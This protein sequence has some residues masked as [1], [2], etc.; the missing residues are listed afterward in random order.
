MLKNGLK[1][2]ATMLRYS[3][4]QTVLVLL[5]MVVASVFTT[6]TV[7]IN[8]N[9]VDSV[10]VFVRER[11]NLFELCLWGVLLFLSIMFVSFRTYFGKQIDI[12]LNRNLI[13]HFVP[14]IMGKLNKVEYSAFEDSETHNLIDRMSNNPQSVIIKCFNNLISLATCIFSIAGIVVYFMNISVV[15]TV[16]Y[17]VITLVYCY[18]NLMIE[19][20]YINLDDKKAECK[21]KAV[22]YNN[23]L[24]QKDSL[25]ELHILN[26]ENYIFSG[27]KNHLKKMLQDLFKIMM[28]EHTINIICNV[29]L[30]IWTG[31]ML[32]YS[33]KLVISGEQTAG[34][35]VAV[36]TSIGT[37]SGITNKL[38]WTYGDFVSSSMSYGYYERF[39]NLPERKIVDNG[40][41][42]ESMEIRFEDVYFKYPGTDIE[43]LK[44]VS[45]TLKEGERISIV[46]ENGAGKSTI[47]K[48]LCGLYAP[49]K[50]KIYVDKF[51]LDQLSEDV[52]RDLFS[53]VFQDFGHYSMT[54]RENVAFGN[55]KRLDDDAAIKEALSQAMATELI[56]KNEKGLEINLGKL[57]SDGIDLSGGQWQRLSIARAFF[58]NARY[59]ILDEPTASLDPLAECRMYE[60]F[61]SVLKT[62]GAITISHRLASA[63]LSDRI[64]VL[65]DGKIVEEGSHDKL[66]ERGG[67][68]ARMFESQASWYEGKEAD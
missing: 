52:K 35:F 63:R 18:F 34:F 22:Y 5:M 17:L 8:K 53:V 1:S 39:I 14:V 13:K 54:L 30:C 15:F 40:L 50:G 60:S 26:G 43:I 51:E 38:T 6:L 4:I 16:V 41:K 9:L 31:F 21:R 64:L 57:E 61:E 32:I 47:I 24:T 62:R 68:Y 2:V 28:K 44:G 25:A 23:L 12:A 29:I 20:L 66:M 10:G 7:H 33:S 56:D 27:W 36:M 49:D 65:A 48:L 67:L 59:V 19:K 58:S 3:P 11:N 45:F 37:L 42:P 55:I 46:G